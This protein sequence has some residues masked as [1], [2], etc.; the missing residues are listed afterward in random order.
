MRLE[1]DLGVQVVEQEVIRER[2]RKAAARSVE[3]ILE[4]EIRSP[5]AG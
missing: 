1:V 5:A 2:L 4:A 3:A